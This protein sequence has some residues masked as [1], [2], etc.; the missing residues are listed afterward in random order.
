MKYSWSISNRG[1]GGGGFN[2]FFYIHKLYHLFNTIKYTIKLPA[3]Y[4]Q[5]LVK[6]HIPLQ[7][8]LDITCVVLRHVVN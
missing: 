2:C 4:H 7:F 1:W 8:H 6:C 5:R 3:L